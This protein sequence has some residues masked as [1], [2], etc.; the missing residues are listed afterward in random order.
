M[1]TEGTDRGV[2]AESD[3][4]VALNETTFR[5]VNEAIEAG[6]GRREGLVPFVCECGG[7]GCNAVVEMTLRE[8]ESV[9]AGS[10]CFLVSPGHGAH[11]DSP[12]R[13]EPRFTVVRKP[14]GPLGELADR[15][16]PR[17]G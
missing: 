1:R 8:Y 6:R 3:G 12:V 13:T 11:F 17:R 16:D 7:L 5:D 4:R 9:R 14:E 2:D 15:T 10:R